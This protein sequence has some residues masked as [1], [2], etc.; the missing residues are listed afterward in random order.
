MR[1][2]C[3]SMSSKGSYE[4]DQSGKHLN[5]REKGKLLTVIGS[6]LMLKQGMQYTGF[7]WMTAFTDI[8]RAEIVRWAAE[9]LRPFAIVRDR[10]FLSLMKTGHPEYYLPSAETVSRDVKQVFVHTQNRIA[11]MLRVR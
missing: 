1:N 5:E 11:K 2:T 3:A 6:I 4:I 8:H 9:S 7:C 10:G